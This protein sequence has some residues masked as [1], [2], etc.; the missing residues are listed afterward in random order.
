VP[1]ITADVLRAR[2][3]SGEPPVLLDVRAAYA[4]RG[5][6]LAGARNMP[7]SLLP[8]RVGELDKDAEIVVYCDHGITSL[9]GA[10]WL[11]EQGYI[12]V[13][14]LAGGITN[15]QASGGAVEG[16]WHGATRR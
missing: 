14:S 7:L 5:A 9:D 11:I 1:E 6:H 12:Q 15:W 13:W 16:D 8:D 3:A 10:G 2:L 4:Y